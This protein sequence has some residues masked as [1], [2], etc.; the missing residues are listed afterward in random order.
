MIV[1]AD[2]NIIVSALIKPKGNTA[3]VLKERSSIQFTAPNYLL[4]EI[5]E[6]WD[7]I[8]DSSVLSIRELLNE[9]E[10]YKARIKFVDVEEI[11]KKHLIVAKEIVKGVDEDDVDFIALYLHTKHKIWTGYKKLIKGLTAKG[12]GHIFVTTAQLKEKLYKR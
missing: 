3:T 2:T 11:S 9:L 8:L 6:H 10:Y 7:V 4:D 5:Y 1:I 12:Y